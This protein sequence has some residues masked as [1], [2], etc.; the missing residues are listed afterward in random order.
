MRLAVCALSAV[1]LSGCSW[2]GMGGHG[3][4]GGA[5]GVNCAPSGTGYYN[6]GGACGVGGGY[7][8]AG[9]GY[10]AGY[11]GAAGYGAQGFGGQ[12]FGAGA[13]GFGGQG[14]GPGAAGYGQAGFG[15][16]SAGFG[17]AGFGANGAGFGAGAGA[18]ANGFGPGF[19]GAG[20]NGVGAGLAANGVGGVNGYNLQG[21]QGAY[22]AGGGV[23]T[24]GQNAAY[25]S[26]VYGQNVVGTQYSNGQYVQGAGVQTIQGAPYYVPQPYPAYYGVPQLRGV[27]AALPFAIETGVG[28][29]FDIGGDLFGGKEAGPNNPNELA[30]TGRVGELDSISY[31]DAFDKGVNLGGNLAYDVSRNTTLIGGVGYSKRNGQTIENGTF[32]SGQYDGSGGFT[33]G[34][35]DSTGAFTAGASDVETVTAEF[36]DLEEWKIEGG[37]RQ[38]LGY[39]PT[40]RPYV[41][42]TGGF[43]H[44]NSVDL[45]QTSSGGTLTA[46]A[47]TQEY[48]DSGWTPTAAGIIGAEMAVGPRAAIGVETGIRWRDDL[49][50]NVKSEDRWSIPVSLRGRVAF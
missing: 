47:N 24:L 25:G 22:G 49:D 12:G 2:L 28:T 15:A 43:S 37:V 35:Y 34:Y 23:T 3:S 44:N 45:T 9:N 46:D 40:F 17:Q 26:A 27:G 48:I 1:L 21:F 50:T 31:D 10:G 36:T 42:A 18:G 13:Q 19:G 5:Y 38:Y 41:G 11:G 6:G 30:A 8:V 20:Y 32:Q 14:F 33:E 7:G 29:E 16:G 39:N 4:A